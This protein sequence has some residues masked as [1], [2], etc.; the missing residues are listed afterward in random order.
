MVLNNFYYIHFIYH[1]EFSFL[2]RCYNLLYQSLIPNSKLTINT[3]K[4]HL[5][6]SNSV[7]SYILSGRNPRIRCQRILNMQIV[8]LDRE[9]DYAQ[10]CHLINMIS[11]ITDLSHRLSIGN[12]Y[13]SI[14]LHNIRRQHT[15]YH[16]IKIYIM[17]IMEIIMQFN[18]KKFIS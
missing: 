11:I 7:E 5:K 1:T 12:T 13:V 6:F 16:D 8:H 3:L 2:I 18:Y 14:V 10:F 17:I 15:T 4:V 9:R